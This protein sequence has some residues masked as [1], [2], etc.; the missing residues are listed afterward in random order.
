MLASLYFCFASPSQCVVHAASL[1]S[2]TAYASHSG[3]PEYV[4]LIPTCA[5]VVN[6]VFAEFLSRQPKG[7][8]PSQLQCIHPSSR[9]E[10]ILSALEKLADL[11]E[12]PNIASR[13]PSSSLSFSCVTPEVYQSQK[14]ILDKEVLEERTA[15]SPLGLDGRP[16]RRFVLINPTSSVSSDG[17]VDTQNVTL[18]I[19]SK[20]RRKKQ[21]NVSFA[22]QTA[23]S[24]NQLTTSNDSCRCRRQ[25]G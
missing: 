8:T 14:D 3:S 19:G 17:F 24:M 23:I 6:R 5:S 10:R 1:R 11:I 9:R 20:H 13:D 7:E 21:Q 12:D 16:L 25:Q 18:T 22:E 4:T 15:F 2:L